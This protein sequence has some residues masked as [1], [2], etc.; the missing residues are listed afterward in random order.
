MADA[1]T[2]IGTATSA[3]SVAIDPANPLAWASLAKNVGSLLG[4]FG[5]GGTPSVLQGFHTQ[6]TLSAA[7]FK[8]TVTAYDQLQNTWAPT[9]ENAWL[10]SLDLTALVTGNTAAPQ[11]MRDYYNNLVGNKSVPIDFTTAADNTKLQPI[12][13]NYANAFLKMADPTTTTTLPAPTIPDTSMPPN[14]AGT[15]T[16]SSAGGGSTVAPAPAA[17]SS[18][19]A[20]VPDLVVYAI[21]LA[22]AY[23][24]Y[25]E[26]H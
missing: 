2:A 16:T 19:V 6:G 17:S 22:I 13:E 10:N 14:S 20:G 5:G 3:A 23:W 21:G 24:I 26:A 9:G 7:G 4:L 25:K 8:G 1:N 11:S 15:V 18:I 12:L